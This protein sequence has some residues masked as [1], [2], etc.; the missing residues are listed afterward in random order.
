M[1]FVSY[2]L[3]LVEEE[4]KRHAVTERFV[5]ALLDYYAICHG[6]GEGDADFY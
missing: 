2:A 4:T 1:D 6:V 5:A 3:E